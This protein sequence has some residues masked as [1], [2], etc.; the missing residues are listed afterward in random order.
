MDKRTSVA[1]IDLQ[2]FAEDNQDTNAAKESQNSES[3]KGSSEVREWMNDL[4]EPLRADKR[5]A[6]FADKA[7]IA[8]SYL[9]L[10]GKLGRSLELPGKDAKDEDWSK[11]FDRAGRP[12]EAGDYALDP[13]GVDPDYLTM[14][15]GMFH[16]AELTP[17]QAERLH[18]ALVNQ[19]AT[20][21]QKQD[22]AKAQ[23]MKDGETTL[24]EVWGQQY[25]AKME[26]A[27][28]FVTSSGGEEA[29][30]HLED[31]GAAN[32]PIILQL[33]A[34]AGEARG[35]HRF[36]TGVTSKGQPSNPYEYMR[37]DL[38]KA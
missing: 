19:A 33:I 11:F 12:K 24:R 13:T 2:W 18:K 17:R 3:G 26:I 36:I 6:K 4:P 23:A 29:L 16:S 9:E 32:D 10:E 28:R 25:D 31:I 22:E 1:L 38:G 5:L 37:K 30:K 34:S 21:K 20:A 27:R 35:P 14:I 15:K 8:K 7:G